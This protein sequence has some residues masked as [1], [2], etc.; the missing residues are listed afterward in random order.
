MILGR[1]SSVEGIGVAGG[2]DHRLH[3]QLV[4]AQIGQMEDVVG[5]VHIVVGEGAAHIVFLVAAG[6][7]ELLELG[8]DG[9]VAALTGVVLAQPVVDFLAAVDAHDHVVHFLIGKLDD[10]VVHQNAVGG[11]GE[12]ELLVVGLLQ[13][14]AVGH[15][16]LDHVPVH[17]GLTA[18]EVHF[19]IPA[20]AAVGHQKVQRLLAHL[21]AHQGTLAVVVALAGEAVFAVQVAG[22][23][24]MQAHGLHFGHALFEIEGHVAVDV[25]G[26]Q[27]AGLL[28]LGNI[29]QALAKVGLGHVL[30]VGVFFQH[31][32]HDLVGGG[33]FVQADHVVGHLVHHMDRAAEYIQYDVVSVEFILMDHETKVPFCK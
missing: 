13:A 33:G 12:A 10:L 27:L 8:H 5:E 16:L 6:L 32:G 26:E 20:L 30:A 31:P 19:Q 14:A 28:Q 24:H 22:V 7:G 23:G 29:G 2:A 21:E 4:K 9:V 17:Q 25:L 3:A 1:S 11:Q 15:Q 18:E